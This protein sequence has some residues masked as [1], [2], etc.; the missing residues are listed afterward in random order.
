MSYLIF[1]N[2]ADAITASKATDTALGMPWQGRNV[3]TGQLAPIVLGTHHWA[4]VRKHPTLAQ[5]SY[6]A[7]DGCSYADPQ[8][9]KIVGAEAGMALAQIT[10]PPTTTMVVRLPPSWE[11]T[12]DK[13]LDKEVSP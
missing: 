3:A 2:E 7:H 12:P 5:Y 11:P 10:V 1:A 13:A 4:T 6:L 9:K 8:G